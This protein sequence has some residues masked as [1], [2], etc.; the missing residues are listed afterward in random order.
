MIA[1]DEEDAETFGISG[2]NDMPMPERSDS[3]SFDPSDAGIS[4]DALTQGRDDADLRILFNGARST[5]VQKSDGT[6]TTMWDHMLDRH[7]EKAAGRL[8]SATEHDGNERALALDYL[9]GKPIGKVSVGDNGNVEINVPQGKSVATL[10]THPNGDNTPSPADILA[11]FN[12]KSKA[13]YIAAGRKLRRWQ[14]L[15]TPEPED[16]RLIRKFDEDNRNGGVDIKAYKN[17]LVRLVSQGY[18]KMEELS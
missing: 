14:W 9:T 13:E 4:L 6:E 2:H 5:T 8:T 1:L 16:A 3:Y 7:M 10:H 18:I 11:G 17:L 15:K 12:L